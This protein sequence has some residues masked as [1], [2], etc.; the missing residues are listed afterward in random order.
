MTNPLPPALPPY[1]GPNGTKH[2]HGTFLLG[3]VRMAVGNRGLVLHRP[4]RDPFTVDDPYPGGP[5]LSAYDRA[6][7]ILSHD[8]PTLAPAWVRMARAR[9]LRADHGEATF[10]PAPVTSP[11][12]EPARRRAKSVA[13]LADELALDDEPPGWTAADEEAADEIEEWR[14]DGFFDDSEKDYIGF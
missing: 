9:F 4:G 13:E 14:K 1:L 11:S 7:T 10:L 3:A 12:P 2:E 6:S 8:V 5:W